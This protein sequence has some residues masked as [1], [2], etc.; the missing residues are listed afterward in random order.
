MNDYWALLSPI[1][2]GLVSLLLGYAIGKLKQ[3]KGESKAER[4]ALGALLRN[5]MYDIFRKYRDEDEVPAEVQEEM[6]SL[7][8]AYHGLGF[9]NLGTKIHDD[10]MSKKTRV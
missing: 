6:H 7:Y 1:Y 5:D 10:I 4:T 3:M 2:G 8:E 9:N